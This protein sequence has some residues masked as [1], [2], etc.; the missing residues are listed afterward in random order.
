MINNAI[1]RFSF[2]T[3]LFAVI[4]LF[5]SCKDSNTQN[6]EQT[7]TDSTQQ[8]QVKE[9]LL[10]AETEK[11]ISDDSLSMEVQIEEEPDPPVSNETKPTTQTTSNKTDKISPEK[12]TKKQKLPEPTKITTKEVTEQVPAE[13]EIIS[14]KPVEVI[15]ETKVPTKEET[16]I[17]EPVE[18]KVAPK[19]TDPV[20]EK[21]VEEV[22]EIIVEETNNWKVPAKYNNKKNPIA[23]DDESLQIGR[24]IYKKHCASCHGKTGRGDGSKAEKLETSTGDFKSSKFQSQSDGSLFYKTIEGRDEMPGYKKKIPDEEDIWHLVNFLR[25]LG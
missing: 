6:K 19:E 7:D 21:P 14:K 16:V 12:T 3:F 2:Y 18:E 17:T 15:S 5:A 13:K 1:Y 4:I 25:S 20:I 9:E 10:P 11:E 22:K 24:V 23:S 8:V